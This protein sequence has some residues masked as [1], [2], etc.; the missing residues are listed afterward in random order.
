MTRDRQW[1]GAIGEPTRENARD[2]QQRRWEVHTGI[3]RP[4]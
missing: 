2:V 4:A 3:R 1:P